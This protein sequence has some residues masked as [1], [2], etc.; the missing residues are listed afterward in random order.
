MLNKRI[1]AVLNLKNNHV[2]H[3]INFN[4]YLPVGSLSV[5]V[6]FLNKWG[7]D[8]IIILDI[9]PKTINFNLF[10]DISKKCHV[11]ITIGGG[12]SSVKQINKLLKSGADKIS[13]N[14]HALDKPDFILESS[15][16][17]GRQCIVV[18]VDV[19]KKNKNYYVYDYR[20]NKVKDLLALDWIKTVIDKGAGEIL[21]N[22]VDNDGC[23]SGYEIDLYSKI[24]NETNVP[25]IPCGG[26]GKP[27]H[28]LKLF[29]NLNINS[30]AAGNFF[31]FTEHS[32]V[33][34][35][36]FL[37]SN[38]IN[39]RL[40]KEEKYNNKILNNRIHKLNDNYLDDLIF[41]K[42]IEEKI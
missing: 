11:P 6:E 13:I 21:V 31:H 17:F 8:E 34:L 12:I 18:S 7:I 40:E 15:K 20:N 32:I 25:I 26:A 10:K 27:E 42:I 35:K 29:K 22:F 41:K 39:V 24:I 33:T 28:F 4:T 9:D 19:T 16:I 30:A 1:I 2:V 37:Q 23:Y 5:S 38:K 14:S 36:S 3:S